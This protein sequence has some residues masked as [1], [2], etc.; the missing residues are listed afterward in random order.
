MDD[1]LN[2]LLDYS[3]ADRG[4]KKILLTDVNE[5]I[6]P[7]VDRRK[8]GKPV[9]ILTHN[10]PIL[11]TNSKKLE[12]VFDILITNSIR[13]NKDNQVNIEISSTETDNHFLFSVKDNGPGIDP[14]YHEKIFVIFQTLE[15]RDKFESAGVGL[16][17][18]KKIVDENGGN[19]HVNSKVGGGS[20][21]EFTWKKIAA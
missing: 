6:Q 5:L 12:Q 1:L 17:I 9:H 21:F 10:L 4:V 14:N 11:K 15:P 18:A 19:I 2:A 16:A 3:R 20:C 8:N 13:F 7:I